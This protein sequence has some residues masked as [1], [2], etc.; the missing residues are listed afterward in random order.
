MEAGT[1]PIF[2]AA[3]LQLRLVNRQIDMQVASIYDEIRQPN[4]MIH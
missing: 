4:S 1:H 3:V 2:V